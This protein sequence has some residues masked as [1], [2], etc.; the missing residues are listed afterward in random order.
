ME[1]ASL[2]F[3][4]VDYAI[5]LMHFIAVIAHGSRKNAG[6][7]AC[8]L[9]GRPLTRHLNGLSLSASTVI[10]EAHPVGPDAPGGPSVPLHERFRRLVVLA[11]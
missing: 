10:G 5:V 2:D 3:P 1:G 9:A 4:S 6:A 7:D 8:P 11:P